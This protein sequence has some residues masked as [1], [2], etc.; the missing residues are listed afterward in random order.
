MGHGLDSLERDSATL[1]LREAA[2]NI[3]F[4][5]FVALC[6]SERECSSWDMSSNILIMGPVSGTLLAIAATAAPI[7]VKL[8]RGSPAATPVAGAATVAGAEAM[9][10]VPPTMVN[11]RW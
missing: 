8:W 7:S 11:L 5:L 9:L 1:A 4:S 3:A 6:S 2:T 10:P